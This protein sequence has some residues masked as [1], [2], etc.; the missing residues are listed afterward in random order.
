MLAFVSN[1]ILHMT[2][3]SMITSSYIILYC[4]IPY[5]IYHITLSTLS[6]SSTIGHSSM[7]KRE[8][9]KDNTQYTIGHTYTQH[10]IKVCAV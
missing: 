3:G 9:A 7:T 2:S 4:F 5:H 1:S 10:K 8:C 6:T